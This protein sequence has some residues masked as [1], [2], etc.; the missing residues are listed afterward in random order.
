MYKCKY[1][2]EEFGNA[3]GLSSHENYCHLNPQ[4]IKHCET[5]NK[6]LEDTNRTYCSYTCSHKD[7]THTEETKRKSAK[8]L[9]IKNLLHEKEVI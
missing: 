5:C 7:R 8:L 6:V 4:N 3:G 1:C 2:E 9:K